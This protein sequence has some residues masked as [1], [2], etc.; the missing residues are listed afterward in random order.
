MQGFSAI[1]PLSLMRNC[2]QK[3]GM[4]RDLFSQN[5]KSEMR[6]LNF[7]LSATVSLFENIN[8]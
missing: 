6:A 4:Q 2:I 3:K 5:G 1:I 8:Q 7:F